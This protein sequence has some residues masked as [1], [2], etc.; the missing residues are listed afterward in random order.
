M[1]WSWRICFEKVC[2]HVLINNTRALLSKLIT[3]NF[4]LK[5]FWSQF[6]HDLIT[7]YGP[8][9]SFCL[10]LCW[11]SAYRIPRVFRVS[12]ALGLPQG[13]PTERTKATHSR[14]LIHGF[15]RGQRRSCTF[16]MS[17]RTDMAIQQWRFSS[18]DLNHHHLVF[19]WRDL[20]C[21]PY[22]MTKKVR[23]WNHSTGENF[24]SKIKYIFG[25]SQKLCF[26]DNLR[27]TS[28]LYWLW[29]IFVKVPMTMSWQ[30]PSCSACKLEC[31][32]RTGMITMLF[33]ISIVGVKWLEFGIEQVELNEPTLP[34]RHDKYS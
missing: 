21:Y 5:R 13:D 33:C 2:R 7:L 6:R 10:L 3:W 16:W 30:V 9:S 26:Y 27:I 32:L 11:S 23:P 4:N 18:G 28:L 8:V 24:P 22:R 19:A 34:K 1:G 31:Y 14:G 20:S 25:T 12:H 15:R 29:Y 17:A